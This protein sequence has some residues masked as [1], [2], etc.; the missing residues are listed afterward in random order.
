MSAPHQA[1]VVAPEPV[2]TP[3]NG[4]SKPIARR[5]KPQKQDA[6]AERPAGDVDMLMVEAVRSGNIEVMERVM[7]IRRE[8]KAEAAREAFFDAFADF[9]AECPVIKKTK[10][11]KSRSGTNLY[12]YAPLDA[13]IKQLGSLISKHGFSY[14]TKP[15]FEEPTDKHPNGRIMARIRI[16]HRAGHVEESEFP[17]PISGATEF[18]N[19]A[20]QSGTALTYAKRYAFC[21]GFGIVTEDED[22]DGAGR[23]TPQQAREARQPVRQPQSTPTAQ[24]ATGAKARVDLEPAAEGEEAIDAN[25]ITGLVKA[26]EHAALSNSDFTKRFPKL[27]GLEQ[28]RKSDARVI[29]SWIADPVK[30]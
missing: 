30:N 6:I 9:Q 16:Q 29:L 2:V 7:A 23:F 17:I 3:E 10:W 15:R 1:E 5:G 19:G 24:R 13:I 8:L 25:T 20:Q 21:G 12:S 27:S 4:Q 22:T 26:M 14:T 11:V 18:T 28:V